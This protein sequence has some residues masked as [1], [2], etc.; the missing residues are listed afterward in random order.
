VNDPVVQA[1]Q[2][3]FASRVASSASVSDHTKNA[4]AICKAWRSA[5]FDLDAVRY[6]CEV[7]V[8]PELEQRI[9]ILDRAT[10]T[11]YE[12]KVSGKNAT[13]EFYRNV[14]KAL[15]WNE[16]RTDK[17][18]RLIFITE[19]SWGRRY[20]DASMPKAYMAFISKHHAINIDVAYVHAA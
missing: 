17:L 6:Q 10:A 18:A 11:A 15:L 13:A 20:L 12:F 5:V 1:A 16:R 14:V 19:E 3:A 4:Q 2:A 8:A 9:D 7:S